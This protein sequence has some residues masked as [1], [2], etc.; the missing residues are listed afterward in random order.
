VLVHFDDGRNLK[1]AWP[2]ETLEHVQLDAGQ[3][4]TLAAT[5]DR[6]VIT[7]KVPSGGRLFYTVALADGGSKTVTEDGVRV[8]IETDP[9]ARLRNGELDSARSVN[10]RLAATRLLFAHQYD[11][12]SSLSNSRVEI[13]PHQVGVLHR[14][15]SSYPH[16]FILADEVGL[17]KTIEAG[18]VIRELKARGFANRVLIL[19]PSGIVSQW[20]FEL[21]TKFNQV[22]ADYRRSSID[23]LQ[24]ENP[25]ENVWAL[26]DNVICSTSFAAYNE[27]R[28]REIALAGW[29]MIVIDEAHHARRR[30]EGENKH[31]DTNLY[32]L[33]EMLADPDVGRAQSFLMLTATPMQLH[34]FELFSLIELLDPALF[35]TF[36]DF[37]LHTDRLAGLNETVEALRRWPVLEKRERTE[38]CRQVQSWLGSN[39]KPLQARLDDEQKRDKVIEE[40]L[41]KH[42]LSNVMIRNRKKVVG[43]FMPRVAALWPV[44]LTPEERAAYEATSQYARTGYALARETQNN[45]LGFLMTIFQKLNTSSSF[46]LRQSL[47]RRIEK[48]E[49]GIRPPSRTIAIEEAD[50]EE[51]PTEE[52]LDQWMGANEREAELTRREIAQLEELVRSLDRIKL[53]SKAGVLIEQLAAIGEAEPDAKVIIFT[54]FRDTQEYLREHISEPWSVNLFHG[55]LKPQEKDAAIARFRDRGGP[56]LLIS[57]EA[58]GEGRNFQF[59]HMVINYDLPWNPM[60]VEQRIGRIDRIGQKETVKIFNFSTLGTIE[61][62]VVEVLDARIGVFQ[63][64]IGGLDPILGEV[65]LDLRKIF[66]AAEEEAAATLTRLERQLSTRVA[67]ARRAE[68][69]LADLIMDTKSFRKDE[70]EQLLERRG[71]TDNRDLRRFVINALAELG[72]RI[73]DDPEVEGAHIVEVGERFLSAFPQ[74]AKEEIKTRVTFDP[75]VALA[76]EEIDFLAFGHQL[77]DALVERVRSQDYGGRS[78]VRLIFTDEVEPKEGWFFVYVLEFGGLAPSKELLPIFVALDGAPDEELAQWLLQRS[79]VG[80]RED[81]GNEL[82]LP[83]REVPFD[84]AVEHAEQRAV[85]RLVTRQAELLGANQERLVQERE[86]LDRFYAYRETAAAEKL[87]SVERV[88]ARLSESD[89]PSV[90]KVLPAWAAKVKTARRHVEHATEERERR[91]AELAQLDQVAAQHQRIAASYVEIRNDPS[92]LLPIESLARDL[93]DRLRALARPT[94]SEEL[95]ACVDRL[96]EH[97]SKL[98]TLARQS[99]GRFDATTALRIA[100]DLATAARGAADLSDQSRALLRGA[101][102][103]FI[104]IEDEEHDLQPGGFDDDRAV[105]EAVLAAITR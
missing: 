94:T 102:D 26:R 97:A 88:F 37:E 17:G 54:Q 41:E 39:S 15:A 84:G 29:D 93:H 77:V 33:A 49:A 42:R 5:G 105:A 65:E 12:L 9:V 13:K 78:G 51:K 58:G 92:E 66:L 87:D 36:E 61:E 76:H 83:P 79:C 35:P 23:W 73:T 63:Q 22:F 1:F 53:D 70:V 47:L 6:G 86:K 90:Q 64:T 10:L 43:G 46:A 38:T 8:A 74:F 50:L 56:Q 103:Y 19:A 75:A 104:L 2:S 7:T 91:V 98:Q 99:K 21:K 48:L 34:R 18:L 100:S 72:A 20:Q 25:G 30:W 28:R 89:D 80:K 95:E 11:E 40:L 68:E 96:H 27:D 4:V 14:V 45:A 44:E 67:E 31:S 52:A 85:E 71:T 69:R 32:K 62:R 60:K 81:Y 59:C 55:Q 24:A 101:I 3:P 82:L 57:T 16:R